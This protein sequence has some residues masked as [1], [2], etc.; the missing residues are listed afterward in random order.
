MIQ[1]IRNNPDA[2]TNKTTT[3]NATAINKNLQPTR[4]FLFCLWVVIFLNK[5]N[6][7]PKT[8]GPS[9]QSTQSKCNNK[10]R[11]ST[12]ANPRVYV[13]VAS[14]T[15]T[16]DWPSTLSGLPVYYTLAKTHTHANTN[17]HRETE[18]SSAQPSV[19]CCHSSAHASS[20]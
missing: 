7:N 15:Q 10:I 18:P 19:H 6:N 4:T 8:S 17:T 20:P 1:R 9:I 11:R 2:H 3:K 13:Y 5:N 16:P 12:S 14:A